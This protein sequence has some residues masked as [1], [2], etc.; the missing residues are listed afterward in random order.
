[1]AQHMWAVTDPNWGDPKVLP[2]TIRA[3]QE[4]AKD[5][6]LWTDVQGAHLYH[7]GSPANDRKGNWDKAYNQGFRMAYIE[8]TVKESQ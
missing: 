8:V 6:F 7:G 5:A 4:D 3:T 2:E 1:M